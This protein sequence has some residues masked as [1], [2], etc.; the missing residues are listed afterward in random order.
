M[1]ANHMPTVLVIDDDDLIR[2][3]ISTMLKK[4]GFTVMEAE[5]GNKGMELLKGNIK[6]DLVITDILMPDKEGLETI[7]EIR[8]LMPTIKIIAISGG[9]KKQD[10][11]FLNLA[12]QVGAERVLQKPF[13]PSELL[14]I[15]SEIYD[16]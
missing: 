7:S 13:R 12:K 11:T 1:K 6:P 8:A 15:I 3:M 14:N 10:M 16:N 5:N 2:K 9:G 4:S